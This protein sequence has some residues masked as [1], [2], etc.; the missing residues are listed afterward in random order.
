MHYTSK[1]VNS[2]SKKILFDLDKKLNLKKNK[3]R[4]LPLG[5]CFL[6]IV[7]KEMLNLN[8]NVCDNSLN[9]MG[10]NGIEFFFG[11]F[12]N[13]LNL[14][15]TLERIKKNKKL[16]KNA[17]TFSKQFGHYICLFTKAR[18]KTKNLD[19]LKKKITEIDR[20]LLEEI[21]KA[22]TILLSFETNEIWIDKKFDKAW[23]SFYGN[24]Y[25][26]KPFA[27]R[28]KLRIITN[29]QLKKIMIS[30][31]K[32]LKK[33]GKKKFI[34]MTSP[35]HLLTT[36]QN[37]DV[38]IADNISKSS[39]CSVFKELEDL[40]DVKYFPSY[41]I[42]LRHNEKKINKYRSDQLHISNKFTNKVLLK[43]FEKSF[44]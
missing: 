34:L 24:I 32:I 43:Y 37:L 33:F 3:E 31:I 21:K 16:D 4:I 22:T 17:F 23:Y 39:Y 42:F 26:Q 13:P 25:K 38:K 14:L 6:D 2:F 35:N 18:F 11:N 41:E 44:F 27:N 8:Y 28:G 7:A 30:I 20:K 29:H 15:H 5:N 19:T 36:Y 12:Y 9:K 1:F 10:K 40:K